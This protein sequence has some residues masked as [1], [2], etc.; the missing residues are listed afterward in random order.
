MDFEYIQKNFRYSI[1]GRYKSIT[2]DDAILE[3]E[4]CLKVSQFLYN[5]DITRIRNHR[6]WGNAFKTRK[7]KRMY[8]QI[9]LIQHWNYFCSLA[10]RLDDTKHYIDHGLQKQHDGIRELVHGK[11]YSDIFKQIIVL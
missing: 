6:E 7:Q 4:S 2:D 9:E 11:V 5:L 10:E 3:R 8:E 1:L